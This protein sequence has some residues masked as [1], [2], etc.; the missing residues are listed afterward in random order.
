MPTQAAVGVSATV[1][2]I[3]KTSAMQNYKNDEF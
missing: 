3:Y 2:R 1:W